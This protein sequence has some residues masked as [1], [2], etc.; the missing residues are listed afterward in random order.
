MDGM[1]RCL[2]LL[3]LAVLLGPA[4]HAQFLSPDGAT[5]SSQFD[6]SLYGIV[7]VRNGSGLPGEFG[8]SDTHAA[9]G[10]SNH[11]TTAQG[12]V[13]NVTATFTFI[14]PKSVDAFYLWNHMS[15]IG[16]AAT[17]GYAIATF[18]LRFYNDSNQLLGSHLNLSAAKNVATAQAYAFGAV[19]DVSSV[20]LTVL[21]N[22]GDA[23]YTGLAEVGFRAVPAVPEPAHFGCAAALLVLGFALARRFF[24][25]A[26]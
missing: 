16:I 23:N 4:A 22:H 14:T 11:W 9:Y 8:P 15:T 13:A 18:S 7:N 17:N 20:V 12:H 24:G 25:R 3:V 1:F 19:D 2:L 26:A 10:A 21:A 6:N 5:T